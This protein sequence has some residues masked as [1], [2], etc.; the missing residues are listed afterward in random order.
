[1]KKGGTHQ[2]KNKKGA[3][4]LTTFLFL[5]NWHKEKEKVSNLI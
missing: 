3:L 4:F 5:I 2:R 1:M